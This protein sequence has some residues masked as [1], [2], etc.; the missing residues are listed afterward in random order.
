MKDLQK[1]KVIEKEIEKI[2]DNLE[3]LTLATE[4]KTFKGP[5]SF[6]TIHRIKKK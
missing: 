2:K 3:V 1:A 5:K 6:L 4:Q